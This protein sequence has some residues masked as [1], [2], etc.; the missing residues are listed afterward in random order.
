MKI[1]ILGY[2]LEGEA[3]LKY[4]SKPSNEITVCD[5]DK[6]KQ[7]PAGVPSRLGPKYLTN[8]NEFDLLVRTAGMN[9]NEIIL[10][11]PE[12]PNILDKVTTS[13]NEFF[14][15]SAGKKII[16]VTGTKGKG[17]TSTLIAKMLETS[18]QRV[19]LG[20][21]IGTPPL[22]M[23]KEPTANS[24]WIVLE[25]SSFQL[26]DIKYSPHIA[27]CMM[28]VP[29]HLDW[30]A[31]V[32][33]YVT[34]KS[35]LFRWQKNSDIAIYYSD[36]PSSKKVVEVS[37]GQKIPFMSPPGAY[38]RDNQIVIDN[39]SILNVS[40]IKLLGKHNWQ[41]VCGA[42]TAFWQ[43][44]EN[45]EAIRSVLT[46]FTGL[47]HRLQLIRE[48]TGVKYYDDSYGTT[49]ET[50]A[51]AVEAIQAPKVMI[52]GGSEK[53]ASFDQLAKTVA[54]DNVKHVVLIGQTADKIKQALANQGFDRVSD[55]GQAIEQ[56]VNEAKKHAESGDAILLSPGCASFGLFKNYKD[57]GEQFQKAVAD[58]V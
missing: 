42:I 20:G 27:V 46:S 5:K 7:I 37:P 1:A 48:F 6:D 51:V 26:I 34:A 35:Q 9:P 28:V 50:A 18:E 24:D 39:Q 25:L 8:L 32:D 21:N 56:I 3:S 16:A 12:A 13:I 22:T 2:A 30:H 58:L 14:K 4:F 38:V 17:T 36:N 41:N 43:I 45:V 52:L 57:R 40:E 54:Q 15:E 55:G 11:N 33:E 10:A 44:N 47:E 29:E 19:H 53:N 49:P 23:L 31:D